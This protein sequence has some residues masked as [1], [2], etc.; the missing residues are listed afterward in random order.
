MPSDTPCCLFEVDHSSIQEFCEFFAEN[1]RFGMECVV[2]PIMSR[3]VTTSWLLD[4]MNYSASVVYALRKSQIVHFCLRVWV[5]V[6][7]YFTNRDMG[8]FRARV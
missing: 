2:A 8:I 1:G 6:Y 4:P 3:F 5:R 7:I